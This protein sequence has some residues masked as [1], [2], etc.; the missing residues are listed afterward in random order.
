LYQN[1]ARFSEAVLA[2]GAS[3]SAVAVA[4][5]T[6]RVSSLNDFDSGTN[7]L[8]SAQAVTATTLGIGIV[9][10]VITITWYS[11]GTSLAGITYTLTADGFL[12]PVQWT[13]GGTCGPAGYC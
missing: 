13:S 11:D 7:G 2:V 9:D 3:R 5:V 10:G 12:P 4:A 6:G 1:K 8:Q